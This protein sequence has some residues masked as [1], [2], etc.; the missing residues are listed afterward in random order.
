MVIVGFLVASLV[1]GALLCLPFFVWNRRRQP[2]PG[3]YSTPLNYTRTGYVL[4]AVQVLAMFSGLFLRDLDPKSAFGAWIRDEGGLLKWW[5]CVVVFS[6]ALNLLARRAGLVLQRPRVTG[7]AAVPAQARPVQAA[8]DARGARLATIAGVPVFVRRSFFLAGAFLALMAGTGLQ[9]ILGYCIAYAALF[10]LHEC[11]HA[12]VAHALGLRVYSVELSGIGGFCRVQTM[13]RT[14]DT[15]L[16][17]SAGLGVQILLLLLTLAGV[18]I[19]GPPRSP[20]A[21][22]VVTTFTWVNAMV[23]L[24]NL[25]PGRT[26][27]G[28]H[29]DGSILWRLWRHVFKD[30]PHPLAEQHA[31]SPVFDPSTR[32]L[33]IAG[34][35]PE[36]LVSG[37]EMLNDDTTPM[38][39]VVAMLQAHAGLAHDAAMAAAMQIHTRGGI[40]LPLA[41]RAHADAAAD[42]IARDAHAQGHRLVCRA[43]T[44]V[45]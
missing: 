32:L 5:A 10:A 30:E 40:L 35:R 14:R 33:T 21:V 23:F 9:G 43:V 19:F 31:A 34:L 2:D 25:L 26:Q 18:S 3:P 11:G 29:T 27:S 45:E 15:W 6:A 24:L 42:A 1:L 17:Y 16:V 38:E 7:E 28:L 8:E 36:G 4:V 13:R 12:V 22:A 41:D 20:W 44:A 39:F 37:I